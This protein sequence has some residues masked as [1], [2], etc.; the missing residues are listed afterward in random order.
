M[1]ILY[2]M[3]KYKVLD[4]LVRKSRRHSPSTTFQRCFIGFCNCF[5]SWYAG[6]KQVNFVEILDIINSTDNLEIKL[7]DKMHGLIIV[8]ALN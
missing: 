6:M 3:A 2:Y 8:C 1:C 7:L 4:G 5:L